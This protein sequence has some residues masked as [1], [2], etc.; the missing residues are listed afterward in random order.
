[1][2]QHLKLS[3]VSE[4]REK[5]NEE[6][7]NPYEKVSFK[8]ETVKQG[9]DVFHRLVDVEGEIITYTFVNGNEEYGI[10]HHITDHIPTMIMA[11]ITSQQPL[12]RGI[13]FAGDTAWNKAK[14][15]LKSSRRDNQ[16]TFLVL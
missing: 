7:A 9:T 12:E 13:I 6:L 8:K 15:Y 16:V 5:P 1:M 11:I 14:I 3:E 10:S 4:M 2:G